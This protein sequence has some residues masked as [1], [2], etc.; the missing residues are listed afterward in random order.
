MSTQAANASARVYLAHASEDHDTLAK[1]LAKTMMANG[2]EVWFDEWEIRTGDSLRRKMEEGL[3][4]CTHFV[5]LLTLIC[6]S[7]G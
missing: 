4:N 6:T 5:V 3:A 7:R 2:I 1:P